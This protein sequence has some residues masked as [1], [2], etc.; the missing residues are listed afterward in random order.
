ML[1]VLNSHT[2]L[3][4]WAA[5]RTENFI[6]AANSVCRADLKVSAWPGPCLPFGLYPSQAPFPYSALATT[7]QPSALL[8]H[9]KLVLPQGPRT[10]YSI[11][12]KYRS[13]R[14][15]HFT[16]SHIC[17]WLDSLWLSLAFAFSSTAHL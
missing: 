7:S 6:T 1:Y 9:S 11:H 14:Y 8:R 3:L 12:L 5:Q 15:S 13:C 17:H 2:W 16:S 10:C 4:F